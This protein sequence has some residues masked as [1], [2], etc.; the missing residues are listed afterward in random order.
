MATKTSKF[1]AGLAIGAFVG[2]AAAI[3]LTP[4]PAD[5]GYGVDE[6]APKT[7]SNTAK[8]GDRIAAAQEQKALEVAEIRK[9]GDDVLFFDSKGRV[10][11][12]SDASARTTTVEKNANVPLLTGYGVAVG[13]AN[14]VDAAFQATSNN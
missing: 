12:R 4:G 5:A 2:L 1:I 8:K 14:R 13:A 11:Y 10:V 3:A 9:L 7:V 6:H